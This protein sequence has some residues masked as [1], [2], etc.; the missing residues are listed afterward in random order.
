MTKGVRDVLQNLSVN[1][2]VATSSSPSRVDCSLEFVDLKEYFGSNVFTASEVNNGKPAPDLFLHAAKMMQVSPEHC[3]VIE[4]ST[5]GVQAALNAGMEVVRYLG[6]SQYTE[7][8]KIKDIKE[9]IVPV[10]D[11]WSTFYTM[12]PELK[13]LK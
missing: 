11:H 9:S 5:Y 6:G 3:L 4:D 2:C 8:M 7:F 1:S 13:K 10:F 12:K